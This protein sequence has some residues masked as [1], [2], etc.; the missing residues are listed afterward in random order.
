MVQSFRRGYLFMAID[1]HFDILR[2]LLPF[3]HIEVVRGPLQVVSYWESRVAILIDTSLQK[4][5]ILGFITD[6]DESEAVGE[7]TCGT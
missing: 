4:V 2:H 6:D 1:K 3:K 5:H 7:T